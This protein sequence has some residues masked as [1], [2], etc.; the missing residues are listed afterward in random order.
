MPLAPDTPLQFV[1]GVGQGRAA[2][3]E[4]AGLTTVRDL[5]FF[6]PFRYEDRRHPTR[7]ADLGRRIDT[8]V[9]LRGRVTSAHAGVTRFKRMRIFEAVLDDG[10]GSVKLIWFNQ[11]YL[12]EQ[13]QRGDRLSVYGAPRSSGYRALSIE[14]PDWEKF[15]GDEDDEGAIV[16]IYSKVG[17]LQPKFVRRLVATALEALPQLSDPLS[18]DL[19]ARL[20]VTD[21]P[22]AIRALHQPPELDDAFLRQRSPAHLRVILQ[23]FFTLQLAL[24]VRRVAEEVAKKSRTIRV[25]DE[26]REEVRRI[27][28]FQLTGAQ[29]RVL[30]EIADDL[31]SDRPMYRLL[32]GDVGSGKTI[33]ALIAAV[34]MIRNG[35]QVA[36]LAP[37]EILVEQHYQRIRQLLDQS[38]IVLARATGSMVAGERR[39]LLAGLRTGYIQLVV[40]THALLEERVT[41]QS[42][43]LA[44]VDEQHRFGVE[45]RQKLFAKGELPDILV[46]T[47]TPIPRSLALAIY[48]DLELSVI[49]E[50]PPGR[51]RIKTVVRA[52]HEVERV[53]DFIDSEIDAGAQT[54][55]VYPIIEESEK[56]NLKPLSQGF[57]SM[58]Q[59][60]PNRRVAMLHGRM[61]SDEKDAVM[62]RFKRGEIDIL[63]AT[64]VIEVGIDVPNA[65]MM[66]IVDADR[67]GLSQLHQLRGRVG[68]GERKS[69]CVLVHDDTIA[70]EARDRLLAFERSRDGFDVA[71]QDLQI[72]GPGEFLGTRQSG[73]M[74]FRFGNIVRDYDLMEKARDLA[75]AVTAESLPRA[76]ET[77]RALLGMPVP[78]A[79]ERD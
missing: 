16:P 66:L 74:R 14:S 32:Q 1:K 5:L 73:A 44:I 52:S 42:L 72:R 13:I 61:K 79:T 4:A 48:G 11:A 62:Q 69:Y 34:L 28:P 56:T 64:T 36:L 10:T 17:N 37:T 30:R 39:T 58:Q 19:R 25:D 67:F 68:R 3:L 43:G 33:V 75:I 29:K 15:E 77:A 8:P 51:Q 78:E 49:D 60:F 59:R 46:M 50:L 6:F 27:L 54:Y 47:A 38:G 55:I 22:T 12:A 57:A 65:S 40:G 53:Y 76:E 35:H 21:L 20:G 9:L 31:Q 24:R 63:V 18:D 26:L 23:E 71:E 2:A 70:G 45:Q 7:I 41:F